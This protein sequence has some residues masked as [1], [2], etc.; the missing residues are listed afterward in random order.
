M[1]KTGGFNLV[2]LMREN[3][4]QQA[5]DGIDAFIGA[6]EAYAKPKYEG[7][8][9]DRAYFNWNSTSAKLVSVMRDILDE[10]SATIIN[11]HMLIDLHERL[12]HQFR[13]GID[14]NVSCSNATQVAMDLAIKAQFYR[15]DNAPQDVNEAANS[16]FAIRDVA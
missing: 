3:D 12:D 14:T 15:K 2:A 4:A 6:L 7:L 8:H 10:N 5:F 9:R 1:T 16:P 13:H 11:S